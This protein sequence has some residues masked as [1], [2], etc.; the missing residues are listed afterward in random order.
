[1]TLLVRPPL[2]PTAALRELWGNPNPIASDSLAGTEPAL[3]TIVWVLLFI[4]I[5][6]PLAVR[7]Y[8]SLNR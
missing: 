6:G 1:M 8:R 5:F 7:K 4:G 3:V 2:S